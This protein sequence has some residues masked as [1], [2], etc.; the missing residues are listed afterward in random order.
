MKTHVDLNAKRGSRLENLT[1]YFANNP[2]FEKVYDSLGDNHT[3]LITGL[4]GSARTLF[5]ASLLKKQPRQ[6]V[7]VT[8][9]VLHAN[10]L[11][12]DFAGNVAEDQLHF[13][14]VEEGIHA[15]MAFASPEA[16]AERIETLS[17]LLSEKA[18]IVIVP[19][20][21]ARKLLPP[22]EIV[23]ASELTVSIG[24]ELEIEEVS[25][26]LIEMGYEREQMVAR[27]GQFGIRGGIIDIYP[28]TEDYP[29][30]IELFDIEVDSLRYFD[31]DTQRSIRNVEG[32]S[33]MP[34]TDQLFPAELLKRAAPIFNDLLSQTL[35]TI[36]EEEEQELL[37]QNLMSVQDA[38]M[39]GEAIDALTPFAG[40]IYPEPLSILDYLS[41]DAV[42]VVDEYSRILEMERSMKEEEAEWVTERLSDRQHLPEIP[43]Y[44]EF[45][46]ELKSVKTDSLFFALFQK[47]MG[48]LRFDE[49]YPFQYRNMQQFF[50]QM[51]LV[52][53]EMTR[54]ETLGYTVVVLTADE[55][56][57]DKVHQTFLDF[58]ID[59]IR[60]E[61]GEIKEGRIQIIPGHL[62]NGFE[63]PRNQIAVLTEK[64][65]FNR[66]TRKKPRRKQL[67]NAER[68]KSYSELS[69]GDFVVHVSHGIGEYTGMETMEIGGVKQ[70]YLS[71]VYRNS[72][73]LLIPV[74]QL[75][76]LQK[77][78]SAE[79]K[80]PRVN[81]LGGTEWAKTKQKVA[82]KVEDI[83]DDLIELYA[84]REQEKGY[85]FTP[86]NAYQKEF[87]D[88]FSYSE[89]EDQLRSTEEIKR[90]MEKE[91]PM[92]RLLVGD[93]GYGKT[94]VAVRAIFKAIQDGK[95]AA[96]LVP[97][98][99]LAQ[100]HFNN[101]CC[102]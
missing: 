20:A 53:T 50:G 78:V 72:D 34:A 48:N 16:R 95:Q 67:S 36:R 52:K 10:Q 32:I 88:A 77:Y 18:G 80:T 22:K 101:G 43:L 97:T 14:P 86:D 37:K 89:T 38:L 70:D 39:N 40:L 81:K 24:S 85:A 61:K 11:M 57:A 42:L 99:V 92:D 8:Q 90:D 19:L 98:T 47:G 33:I 66:V 82:S 9:N 51:P 62:L 58:E 87:E 75:D 35:E 71:V 1:E 4:A 83:A 7:I 49:V 65:L 63:L 55:G 41:D 93:V 59:S 79:G 64:E 73:R 13:F 96:F 44:N 21:G 30:R 2:S 26:Q 100:Q 46:D 94:E 27:P 54:W 17:F 25:H 68:L 12:E 15:D 60:S 3:Q 29:I 102:Y 28:L 84:A 45:R 5:L 23:K 31:P 76:L 56:R 74:T 69:P 91:K 6:I